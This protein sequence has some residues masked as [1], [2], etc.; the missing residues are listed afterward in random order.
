M[1]NWPLNHCL[2]PLWVDSP[3]CAGQFIGTKVLL[4]LFFLFYRLKSNCLHFKFNPRVKRR[5]KST[6]TQRSQQYEGQTKG[7][8]WATSSAL[9]RCGQK[10]ESCP[11]LPA[12]LEIRTLLLLGVKDDTLPITW[13]PGQPFWRRFPSCPRCSCWM[14]FHHQIR[15]AQRLHCSPNSSILTEGFVLQFMLGQSLAIPPEWQAMKFRAFREKQRED[16]LSEHKLMPLHTA[17]YSAVSLTW[18][19]MTCS[20]LEEESQQWGIT[21]VFPIT[22]GHPQLCDRKAPL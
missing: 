13:A 8:G 9:T 6:H 17:E 22:W 10:A 21:S 5:Y 14:S 11:W 1:W 2:V 16:E 15:A 18:V 19:L 12:K 7:T 4:I 20:V 3:K